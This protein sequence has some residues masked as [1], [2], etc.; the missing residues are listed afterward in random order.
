MSL[1]LRLLLAV[2]AIAII[3]LVVADF[4]TYSAL[5]SSLYNQVDQELAAHPQIGFRVNTATGAVQCPSPHTSFGGTTV[6]A[7]P[8]PGPGSAPGDGDERGFANIFGISYASVVNKNGSVVD[9][10]ECPAYVGKNPYRPQLPAPNIKSY[11]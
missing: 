2:G 5:R 11:Y 10:L 3:A 4:A 6:E 8:G 7:G 1:R 9:D